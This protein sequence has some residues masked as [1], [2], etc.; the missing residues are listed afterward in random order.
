[1]ITSGAGNCGAGVS[2]KLRAEAVVQLVGQEFST[3]RK[4]VL[5][6]HSL[7]G[8]EFSIKGGSV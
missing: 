5:I 2:Y 6:L 7:V 8:Q 3:A 4:L 1:M